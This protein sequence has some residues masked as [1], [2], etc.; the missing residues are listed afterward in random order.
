LASRVSAT[1]LA[2]VLVFWDAVR[3]GP[4]DGHPFVLQTQVPVQATG[5]VLLDDEARR[6]LSLAPFLPSWLGPRV[7]V[8]LALVLAELAAPFLAR[9]RRHQNPVLV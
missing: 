6:A 4:G 2:K 5:A 9:V 1:A 8:A 3:H 7:K